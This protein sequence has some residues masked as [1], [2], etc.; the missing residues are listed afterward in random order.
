MDGHFPPRGV[1]SVEG[2]WGMCV[3]QLWPLQAG[4]QGASAATGTGVVPVLGMRQQYRVQGLI[5]VQHSTGNL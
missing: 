4:Q 1:V 5:K 2:V 3:I